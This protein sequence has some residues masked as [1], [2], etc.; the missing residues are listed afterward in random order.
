MKTLIIWIGIAIIGVLLYILPLFYKSQE[1][2]QNLYKE[3]TLGDGTKLPFATE[4]EWKEFVEMMGGSVNGLNT[5]T[6]NFSTNN[7]SSDI[8]TLIKVTKETDITALKRFKKVLEDL[9]DKVKRYPLF[10]FSN[11]EKTKELLALIPDML[12]AINYTL[13]IGWNIKKGSLEEFIAQ[14]ELLTSV[15]STYLD[16][17]TRNT[18]GSE[19]KTD[20][21]AETKADTKT[22]TGTMISNIDRIS[23][24]LL[25]KALEEIYELKSKNPNII[26]KNPLKSSQMIESIPILDQTLSAVQKDGWSSK[27]DNLKRDIQ[28]GT[29]QNRYDSLLKEMREYE[30]T[31]QNN[32][33]KSMLES[34]NIKTIPNAR[35]GMK[36]HPASC[37]ITRQYITTPCEAQ[38]RAHRKGCIPEKPKKRRLKCPDMSDYIRKD[39]IPCWACKL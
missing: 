10:Q 25:K 8:P 15:Y 23:I 24:E 33:V 29:L 34:V 37:E 30:A 21:K 31:S 14:V 16:E 7:T 22:E 35:D 6:S 32:D 12:L 39:S 5:N 20:T 3:I 27:T 26:Y 36:S 13:T 28:S 1:G 2:F 18:A 38:G 17:I 19:T 9:L 4:G 11:S